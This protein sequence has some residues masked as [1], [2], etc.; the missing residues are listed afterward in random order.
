MV[1]EIKERNLNKNNQTPLHLAA[2]YDS[3]KIGKILSHCIFQIFFTK[4][5]TARSNGRKQKGC[6]RICRWP[7]WEF[8]Q[9]HITLMQ[10]I[11]LQGQTAEPA[12]NICR[13]G[14]HFR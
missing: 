8:K 5:N 14:I 4:I 9:N 10:Q 7:V 13:G 6:Q 11:Q 12:E 2:F 1:I 3:D